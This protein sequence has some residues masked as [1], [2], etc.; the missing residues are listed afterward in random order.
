V[1]FEAQIDVSCTAPPTPRA[2][3]RPLLLLVLPIGKLLL[4]GSRCGELAHT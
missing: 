3:L 4:A 2:S 1:T